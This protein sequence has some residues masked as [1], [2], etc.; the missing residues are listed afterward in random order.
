MASKNKIQIKSEGGAPGGMGVGGSK[1]GSGKKKVEDQY[2]TMH[3]GIQQAFANLLGQHLNDM[4]GAQALQCCVAYNKPCGCIRRFIIAGAQWKEANLPNYGYNNTDENVIKEMDQANIGDNQLHRASILIDLYHRAAELKKE[5]CYP[6]PC[7]EGGNGTGNKTGGKELRGMIGLGNGRK[8]S[9]KY[10]EFVMSQRQLLRNDYSLCEKAAMKLLG[11]SINFLYKKLRTNPGKE[12]RIVTTDNATRASKAP[13]NLLTLDQLKEMADPQQASNQCCCRNCIS[14]LV[15]QHFDRIVEWRKRLEGSGQRGA[16]EI[17]AEVLLVSASL[18]GQN[19][20]CQNLVH[21]V[22]GCSFK[23]IRR[24]RDHLKKHPNTLPEHGLKRYWQT[25]SKRK[26]KDDPQQP[27]AA[28]LLKIEPEV[29]DGPYGGATYNVQQAFAGNNR[30][31]TQQ[32]RLQQQPQA[33]GTAQQQPQ[34]RINANSNNNRFDSPQNVV[35]AQPQQQQQFR[36]NNGS[37]QQLP[38]IIYQQPQ[39]SVVFAPDSN[40]QQQQYHTAVTSDQQQ[41]QS[42]TTNNLQTMY[43]VYQP[44]QQQPQ[45]QQIYRHEEVQQQPQ[46]PHIQQQ[47]QQQTHVIESYVTTQ[48]L[49][50]QAAANPPAYNEAKHQ[51]Q[52]LYY[53][54]TN[55]QGNVLKNGAQQSYYI[56]PANKSTN[57]NLFTNMTPVIVAPFPS[58]Q[59]VQTQQ[60]VT[61]AAI[62]QDDQQQPHQMQQQDIGINF[63]SQAQ[64]VLL[65]PALP[66]NDGKFPALDGVPMTPIGYFGQLPDGISKGTNANGAANAQWG[67]DNQSQQQFIFPMQ[68]DGQQQTTTIFT[69]QAQQQQV[70]TSQPGQI[71]NGQHFQQLTPLIMQPNQGFQNVRFFQPII[72]QQPVSAAQQQPAADQQTTA[73]ADPQQPKLTVLDTVDQG[74][75][76]VWGNVAS[77]MTIMTNQFIGEQPQVIVNKADG[78]Q[79]AEMTKVQP[80]IITTNTMP[81]VVVKD[82]SEEG[83]KAARIGARGNRH[84]RPRIDGISSPKLFVVSNESGIQQQQQNTK[85]ATNVFNFPPPNTDK[86]NAGE[87]DAMSEIKPIFSQPQLVLTTDGGAETKKKSSPTLKLPQPSPNDSLQTPNSGLNTPTIAQASLNT[88]NEVLSTPTQVLTSPLPTEASQEDDD[89]ASVDLMPAPSSNSSRKRP[90][91]PSDKQQTIKKI[92]IDPSPA[93]DSVFPETSTQQQSSSSSSEPITTTTIKQPMFLRPL[94]LSPPTATNVV[95]DSSMM[96]TSSSD[97]SQ[98]LNTPV[99]VLPP[100]SGITPAA[101]MHHNSTSGA[102]QSTPPQIFTFMQPANFPTP[103]FLSSGKSPM[104]SDATSGGSSSTDAAASLQ[105]PSRISV[106]TPSA[107]MN[108]SSTSMQQGAAVFCFQEPLAKLQQTNSKKDSGSSST[109]VASSTSDE[110]SKKDE[111]QKLPPKLVVQ[112]SSPVTTCSPPT[113][114]TS[115][116]KISASSDQTVNVEDNLTQKKSLHRMRSGGKTDLI[117]PLSSYVSS[118]DS[119]VVQSPLNTPSAIQVITPTHGPSSSSLTSAGNRRSN[120]ATGLCVRPASLVVGSIHLGLTSTTS[121]TTT[122]NNNNQPLQVATPVFHLI[123]PS[124]TTPTSPV[125]VY[126]PLP[127]SSQSQATVRTFQQITT[128]QQQLPHAAPAAVVVTGGNSKRASTDASS[129]S[130]QEKVGTTSEEIP[131]STTTASCSTSSS[132]G[133]TDAKSE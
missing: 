84:S 55:V 69:S 45:T 42:A 127:G 88:P 67:Q 63:P 120:A 108:Q 12:S 60:F 131:V 72:T 132:E 65:S 105:T 38:S 100:R 129:S 8:R 32:L 17:V 123:S 61:T 107:Y 74:K 124:Q 79:F 98:S 71:A 111:Q 119:F 46:Q 76:N 30:T 51:Q 37:E 56:A 16:Q 126:Q 34:Q 13:R 41:Q 78:S 50:Q 91:A 20:F 95:T 22:T 110:N 62:N 94:V 109:T 31:N 93:T 64:Y 21:W 15:K 128:Q 11:Y 10:E 125:V 82:D 99:F 90:A 114:S 115:D 121:T 4:A 130:E 2:L 35:A 122:T 40:N 118:S 103:M 6:V 87:G 75:M 81:T 101:F 39:P 36:L 73:Q 28:S 27:G 52:Q 85:V 7:E 112:L 102:Q 104:K 25:K 14:W 80:Q 96:M 97:T 3:T 117:L 29:V 57:G 44:Q 18:D 19:S 66:S 23:K 5:K 133:A 33:T 58:N 47:P 54:T 53:Q 113:T 77:N 83:E 89:M 106:V 86:K 116:V 48:A 59:G 68:T 24:I 1:S 9:K 92:L 43:S 70:A 49:P 26:P